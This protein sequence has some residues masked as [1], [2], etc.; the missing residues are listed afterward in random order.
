MSFVNTGSNGQIV[1]Q[2]VMT[3]LGRQRYAEGKFNITK[4]AL[5]DDGV[6]YTLSKT[7]IQNLRI[8]KPPIDGSN[9][10]R[11]KLYT[12]GSTGEIVISGDEGAPSY[13]I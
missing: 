11:Y 12:A 1:I 7:D 9:A 8:L 3:K 10:M 5:S 13:E 2:A 4:F 6:D